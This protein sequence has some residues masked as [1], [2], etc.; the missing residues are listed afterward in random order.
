MSGSGVGVGDGDGCAYCICTC[1]VVPHLT[2]V[3]VNLRYVED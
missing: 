3:L 1:D 2:T